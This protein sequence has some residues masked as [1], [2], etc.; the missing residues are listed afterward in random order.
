MSNT[1]FLISTVI[2][3][4][5]NTFELVIPV[6][7]MQN[8]VLLI[9]IGFI[10]E[11]SNYFELVIPVLLIQNKVLLIQNKVLPIQIGFFSRTYLK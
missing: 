7:L 4:I 10:F 9:Q 3:L 1:F 5:G 8:N 11:I 6:L 2:V